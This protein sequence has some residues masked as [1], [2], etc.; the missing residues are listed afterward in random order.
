MAA[1]NTG[2]H[3][4]EKKKKSPLWEI[5]GWARYQFPG[6]ISVRLSKQLYKSWDPKAK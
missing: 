4:N 6:I 2:M 5:L 3:L 1:F